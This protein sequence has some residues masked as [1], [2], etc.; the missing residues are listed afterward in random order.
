MTKDAEL[1]EQ[2]FEARR[3]L[4]SGDSF[5]KNTLNSAMTSMLMDLVECSQALRKIVN[6]IENGP[7]RFRNRDGMNDFLYEAQSPLRRVE[8]RGLLRETLQM[9]KE[10]RTPA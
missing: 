1:V 6:A 8:S 3:I 7:N 10:E 5:Y 4:A 2:L 9:I